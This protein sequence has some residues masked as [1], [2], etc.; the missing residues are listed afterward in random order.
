[1]REWNQRRRQHQQL[2]L[3]W[4][5]SPMPLQLPSSYPGT[6]TGERWFLCCGTTYVVVKAFGKLL[7]RITLDCYLTENRSLENHPFGCGFSYC[8]KIA[9]KLINSWKKI[10]NFP[11]KTIQQHK[12]DKHL[13]CLFNPV[14][15]CGHGGSFGCHRELDQVAPSRTLNTSH[16]RNRRQTAIPNTS[17]LQR[18]G[19]L[20]EICK[21]S[22]VY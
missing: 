5:E 14:N 1:M 4:L 2:P 6:R 7:G 20:W 12:N 21:T 17:R 19:A 15:E 22:V 18:N 16:M 10:D 3:V 11:S 9:W 8:M 13:D